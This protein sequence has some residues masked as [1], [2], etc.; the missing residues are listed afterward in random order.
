M[1]GITDKRLATFIVLSALA[2]V[3]LFVV[4]LSPLR[5]PTPTTELTLSGVVTVQIASDD[6][7]ELSRRKNKKTEDQGG[8]ESYKTTIAK[9]GSPPFVSRAEDRQ[10]TF[11][12]ETAVRASSGRRKMM[13]S[14]LQRLLL[15]EI[16]LH[17]HYPL[18]ALRMGQQGTARVGF[19]LQKNGYIDALAVL[20]SSGHESL[21][22][23]ALE[24][25]NDIQPFAPAD[26]LLTK[27]A[28]LQIDIVFQL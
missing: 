18:S 14:E 5:V 3:A 11:T 22:R 12:K 16:N 25:I 24:A 2:H 1:H 17:K 21:D 8:Q 7:R 28:D 9:S 20:H 4:S 6:T 10:K 13:L 27:T 26:R 23:A 15:A 19:R